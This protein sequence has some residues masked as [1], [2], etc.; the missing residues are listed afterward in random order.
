MIKELKIIC[1][2]FI[3]LP[4]VKKKNKKIS[5]NLNIYRNLHYLVESKCK[6]Q[7]KEEI[8]SQIESVEF[9]TPVEI[10]YQVFKQSKRRLDKMNVIS[11]CSKYLMDAIT[12]FGCWPDDDDETIKKEIILPTELDRENP[13]IE[14]TI[15]CC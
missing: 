9:E 6:K 5:I 11:I 10:T 15:N 8:R 4:R 12:E 13:R 2:S 3:I 7:F 14:V 1:P